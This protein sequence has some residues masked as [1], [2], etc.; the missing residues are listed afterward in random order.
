MDKL[1][2]EL[3]LKKSGTNHHHAMVVQKKMIN[4]FLNLKR[5]AVMPRT[6]IWRPEEDLFYM[7]K[8]LPVSI[9]RTFKRY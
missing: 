2:P 3:H 9:K 6:A 8:E 1:L 4:P 7:R 5:P